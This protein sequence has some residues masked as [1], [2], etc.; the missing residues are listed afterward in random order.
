MQELGGSIDFKQYRGLG[1]SASAEEVQD[2]QA[3]LQ[4]VLPDDDSAKVSGEPSKKLEEMSV[5]ELKQVITL[6]GGV[7]SDCVE[8]SDLLQRAREVSGSA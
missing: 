8:K 6:H 5:K 2:V 4:R 7:T 3:F 1:H